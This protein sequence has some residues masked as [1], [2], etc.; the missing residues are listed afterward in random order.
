[1]SCVKLKSY[2]VSTVDPIFTVDRDIRLNAII[3]RVRIPILQT[4]T[5][6]TLNSR[7]VNHFSFFFVCLFVIRVKGKS[8]IVRILRFKQ[9]QLLEMFSTLWTTFLINDKY[10]HIL[11]APAIYVSLRYYSSCLFNQIVETLTELMRHAT[12][13]PSTST[14]LH[15]FSS[16]F[17][18]SLNGN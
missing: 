10:P 5:Y 14:T 6:G 4:P 2:T 15:L 9:E 11:C 7:Q 16:F 18:L 17:S 13:F 3:D 12:T 1:M 8:F